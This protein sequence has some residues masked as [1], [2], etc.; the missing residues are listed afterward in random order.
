MCTFDTLGA[1]N[2]TYLWTGIP[3]KG[4][5]ASLSVV[6]VA[7]VGKITAKVKRSFCIKS[8]KTLTLVD[9]TFAITLPARIGLVRGE[10]ALVELCTCPERKGE[11]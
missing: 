9:A 4:S 11:F 8:V 2:C 1:Q 5:I 3:C 7:L 10:R 6:L